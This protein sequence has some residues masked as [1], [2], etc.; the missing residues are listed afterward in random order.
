MSATTVNTFPSIHSFTSARSWFLALIVLLHVGFFWALS[1]GLSLRP[2][3]DIP[4][5][6]VIDFVPAPPR[7]TRTQNVAIDEHQ[8]RSVYTPNTELPR[9]IFDEQSG[10]SPEQ[11]SDGLISLPNGHAAPTP[12]PFIV[13]PQI[14]PRIGLSEPVYPS[15]EIRMG[16]TGTVIVLVQVLPNGRIGEVRIHKSSGYA[17]LDQSA[18]REAQ[19]WSM[20]PGT[21]DG[22]PV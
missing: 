12:A 22:V 13:E 17:K 9:P 18:V 16:H 4:R 6:T 10:A 20:R 19:R 1:N 15:Q 3:V 14:D 2:P 7:P 5:K 8:I 11:T 21:R